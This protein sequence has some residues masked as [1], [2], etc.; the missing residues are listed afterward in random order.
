LYVK[1]Y[2]LINKNAWKYNTNYYIF[3]EDTMSVYEFKEY[4]ISE[5][6]GNNIV[7]IDFDNLI[8]SKLYYFK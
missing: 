3:K 7:E 5:I 4:Y 8:P 6:N 2:E 1:K